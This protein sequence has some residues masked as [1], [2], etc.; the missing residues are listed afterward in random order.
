[1]AAA[2]SASTKLVIYRKLGILESD[3]ITCLPDKDFKYK[4]KRLK[5]ESYSDEDTAEIINKRIV[6]CPYEFYFLIDNIVEICLADNKCIDMIPNKEPWALNHYESWLNHIKYLSYNIMSNNPLY[7]EIAFYEKLGVINY[8]RIIPDQKV[9][10]DYL[11]C[12][13]GK[14]DR[15][16]H[17]I[18]MKD[19][20]NFV[21]ENIS[22]FVPPVAK[23]L[24]SLFLEGKINQIEYFET[25]IDYVYWVGLLIASDNRPNYKKL[26]I[27]DNDWTDFV[28][29][30][31][32]SLKKMLQLDVHP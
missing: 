19:N 1:M 25:L 21:M 17:T 9:S 20:E 4:I 8:I 14:W 6:G 15:S 22:Y 13:D 30:L 28:E 11:K 18:N 31:E 24:Y 10:F 12:K 5:F 16:A 29:M 26:K 23:H 27:F 7:R 3:N 2:T 32:Q